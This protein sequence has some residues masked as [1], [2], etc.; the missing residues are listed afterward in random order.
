VVVVAVV[1]WCGGEEVRVCGE[2]WMGVRVWGG[3]GGGGRGR[4]D[5]VKGGN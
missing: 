1:C 2:G 4:E 5:V 3:G